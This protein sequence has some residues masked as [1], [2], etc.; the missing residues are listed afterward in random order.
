MYGLALRAF[1]SRHRATYG[2]E[3][4]DAFA[5]QWQA[6]RQARGRLAA[7]RF[8]LTA[9]A[10]AVS[11]GLGERRRERQRQSAGPRRP[12][13]LGRDLRLAARALIKARG[14][15]AVCVLSLGIG[16]G[17][18]L[19]IL[20]FMRAV[21]S[22]PPGVRADGLVEL[23]IERALPGSSVARITDTWSYPDFVDVAESN[24]G[25]ELTAWTIDEIT[26]G[27]DASDAAVRLSAMYVSPNYFRTV[28][29]GLAQGAGFDAAATD[30]A[31]PLVVVSDAFAR[32][33]LEAQALGRTVLI[34]RVA[35]LVAAVAAEHFEGHVSPEESPNIH[36]WIPLARHPRL[37]DASAESLRHDRGT[38]WLRVMG[39]LAPDVGLAQADAA[40]A[41]VMASL[42][43]T[44]PATNS[45]K[46]ASVAP[47]TA[48]GARLQ[49]EVA[50]V[51][52]MLLGAAGLVLLVVCLNISGMM[53][54]RG[55]VRERELA[56]RQAIGAS[57]GRLVQYLL[58]E[59][60]VLALAGGALAAFVLFG[61]LGAL[62]WW[63][64][65]SSSRLWPDGPMLA[66]ALGLCLLTS[67]VFGLLPALRFSRPSVVSA[68]R[69][70]AG[71][72]GRRVGR[73]QRL[74]AVFQAAIAVPFLIL[75]GA[76]L[77]QVRTTGMAD[78]GFDTETLYALPLDPAA[79][80]HEGPA[81]A[82]YLRSVRENVVQASGVESVALADGLPL[83]FRRRLV[84]VSREDGAE[85][86]F[87]HTTR[88]DPAY[89]DAMG[90]RMLGGRGFTAGDVAGM[91]RVLVVSEPLAQRV[92][93][94]S[95]V[96]GERLAFTRGDAV[97]ERVAFGT[98]DRNSLYTI[99]GVTADVVTSQM[100]TPR[101]Q[102]YVPLAQDP[103]SN[104]TL[105]ARAEA[106]EF[107]MLAAFENAVPDLEP[108]VLRSSLV[109]G[110]RLIRRSMDDLFSHFAIAGICAAV[111]LTLA[112]LGVYGVVG[113]MVATRRREIGVRIALGASRTRVLGAVTADA[114]RLVAPGA[115]VG[116]LGG[117]YWIRVADPAWY[118]LGSVEPVVYAAAIGIV[119]GVA[120]LAGLPS[121]R[122]AAAVDPLQAIRAE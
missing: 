19:A 97:G 17:A 78:L 86:L 48:M 43:G 51:R 24:T 12:L 57:R 109:T 110:P 79:L 4:S 73:M 9:S 94:R 16:I 103:T 64:E 55:A 120:A 102:L 72:G 105:I 77:D 80:G 63:F 11:S 27:V 32:R 90:I 54:V 87:A 1:P 44:Y 22:P 116:L 6:A 104:V 20:L 3:M 36:V 121:A 52:A 33:R 92:F 71:V 28:G 99:V 89:F 61:G 75:G 115:A 25:L 114:M 96:I 107:A 119:V 68:L 81:A 50:L 37:D 21:M 66:N 101:P 118:A 10:D 46:A 45:D 70:E 93:G 29:A 62:L 41:S 106:N 31:V 60:V 69:D 42:T 84:R 5:Q 13:G 100:G 76:K 112:A 49:P 85:A 65:E 15:T 23:L 98:G 91:E 113:F 38:A 47:Y 39:R 56:V 2:P 122:R 30:P 111:L 108:E 117:I 74:T 34:N 58:S 95:D 40:V 82:A 14:F 35:H 59:A 18:V 53:L 7:L 8:A 83:D 88:V 67:L 26:L